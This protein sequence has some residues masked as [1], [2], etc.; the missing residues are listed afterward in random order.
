MQELPLLPLPPP[1]EKKRKKE[2][3]KR[4]KEKKDPMRRLFGPEE[5]SI[6]F[7][8]PLTSIVG[9]IYTPS[10]PPVAFPHKGPLPLSLA[11]DC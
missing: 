5:S 9:L 1:K 2:K 8:S 6:P 11:R 7:L 10:Q 4:K 3:E